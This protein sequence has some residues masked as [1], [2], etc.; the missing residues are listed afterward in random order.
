MKRK[1]GSTV[2]FAVAMLMLTGAP[3][4]GQGSNDA[5]GPPCSDIADTVLGF[6]NTQTLL[7]LEVVLVAPRCSNVTYS[8][9]LWTAQGTVVPPST[10]QWSLDAKTVTYT[11]SFDNSF[12]L[13]RLCTEASTV[14]GP[15]HVSDYSPDRLSSG[16]PNLGEQGQCIEVGGEPPATNYG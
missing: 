16:E 14:I 5:Q 12:W 10:T 13:E 9:V 1:T 4:H 3:S 15:N 7:S 6:N 2:I 8:G 11:W